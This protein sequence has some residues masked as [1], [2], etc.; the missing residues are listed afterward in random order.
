LSSKISADIIHLDRF[1]QEAQAASA[2]N[3][4]N[5][6]TVFDIDEFEGKHFIAVEYIEGQT[7]RERMKNG[8][9][10]DETLS[11]LIQ[12]AEALSAAHAAG[13]I[14]RDIKPE[15]I[16]IRDDG[17][18]KVLDLWISETL[19]TTNERKERRGGR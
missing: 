4:P 7:L 8:L 19:R 6:I 16:M 17:Y 2:L 15:N 5:I 13:I 1:R 12:T 11:I 14:H 18:V 3:H 9:T 10:F